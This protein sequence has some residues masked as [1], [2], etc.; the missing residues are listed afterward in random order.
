MDRF[1]GLQDWF[2]ESKKEEKMNGT[3][4]IGWSKI[5]WSYGMGEL[6]KLALASEEHPVPKLDG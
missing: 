3:I 6:Y 2:V 4:N 5:A 1:K